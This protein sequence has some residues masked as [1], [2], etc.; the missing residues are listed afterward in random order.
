M[1]LSGTGKVDTQV[2]SG[3]AWYIPPVEVPRSDRF[4]LRSPATVSRVW[5]RTRLRSEIPSQVIFCAHNV[6]DLFYV[7]TSRLDTAKVAARGRRYENWL[8]TPDSRCRSITNGRECDYL[9]LRCYLMDVRF[10]L[11]FVYMHGDGCHFICWMESRGAILGTWETSSTLTREAFSARTD[12]RKK[13]TLHHLNMARPTGVASACE[14]HHGVGQALQEVRGL[15][16]FMM[17]GTISPDEESTH[18]GP[19][20]HVFTQR[21]K[22]KCR[23]VRVSPLFK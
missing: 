9:T 10:W 8:G 18:V 14:A 16:F 23:E 5:T 19:Y 15:L 6:S 3:E 2:W 12:L 11:V 20:V 21:W 17:D 4:S 1:Q 22:Q 13:Q 7:S